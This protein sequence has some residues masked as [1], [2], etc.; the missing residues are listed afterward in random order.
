VKNILVTGGTGF[1]GKRLVT[2]LLGSGQTVTVFGR[3]AGRIRLEFGGNARGIP[4][5]F[6]DSGTWTQE[7][8]GR[9]AIIHLAG[10]PAV[11]RR[12]SESLKRKIRDSR[13]KS[14]RRLV[15]AIGQTAIKPR[16]FICASGVGVY[17]AHPD[18]GPLDE[19]APIGNDFMSEVC[20]EWESAA[21]GAELFGVRVVTARLGIV[22][23]AQGGIV[24]KLLPL[25][26]R[27][28]GGRL[29]SGQQ[30]MSWISL[31]DVVSA[32]LFCAERESIRGPVNL[33][34]PNFVT[35]EQFTHELAESVHRSALFRVPKVALRLALGEVATEVLLG[36]QQ[37]S[38]GVL[39]REGFEFRYPELKLALAAAIARS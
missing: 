36:G 7:L 25:F 39:S 19:T 29:G 27:G 13:V 18:H 30:P 9:D 2:T 14:T 21:A 23:G 28:L 11:G 4:W 38:P 6:L 5:N 12:L 34:A 35:N 3:D 33:V 15:D 24:E 31:D 10:E 37:V 1:I 16:V 32:L 8:S 17:G 20:H 26:Q 22:I